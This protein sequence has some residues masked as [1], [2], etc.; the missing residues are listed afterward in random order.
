MS[1]IRVESFNVNIAVFA[2][3]RCIYKREVRASR[4]ANTTALFTQDARNTKN[5]RHAEHETRGSTIGDR[6]RPSSELVLRPY[7]RVR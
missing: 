7:T 5:K 3:L 2:F 4:T 6:A 1:Q